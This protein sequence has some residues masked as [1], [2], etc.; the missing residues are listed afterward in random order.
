MPN[1]FLFGKERLIIYELR[2]S[3]FHVRVERLHVFEEHFSILLATGC[4]NLNTL[5][6][7]VCGVQTGNIMEYLFHGHVA[8][9]EIA[10][11][12]REGL[13]HNRK[14]VDLSIVLAHNFSHI[15]VDDQ[16][17][18]YECIHALDVLLP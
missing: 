2:C 15:L 14:R 16:V 8:L 18:G 1:L 9:G 10:L 6:D 5:L 4:S 12:I 17:A 11:E 7:P 3:L 13:G